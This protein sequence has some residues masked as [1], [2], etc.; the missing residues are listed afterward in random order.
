MWSTSSHSDFI[1]VATA[2]WPHLSDP[3]R[4]QIARCVARLEQA[5]G[6]LTAN[7]DKTHCP[8]G[9]PY[10]GDNLLIRIRNGQPSRFCR[11]CRANY[12]EKRRARRPGGIEVG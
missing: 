6:P 1:T 11:Q 2:L 10:Q 4:E 5:G 7:R 9:H 3:K 8:K 12:D